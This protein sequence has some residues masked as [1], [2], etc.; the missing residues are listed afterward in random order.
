MSSVSNQ[1]R[2]SALNST[3]NILVDD[4]VVKSQ[5]WD[6][7]G[8]ERFASLACSSKFKPKMQ[9][10]LLREHLFHV[11]RKALEASDKPTALP[12]G[13]TINVGSKDDV[14]AVKTGGFCST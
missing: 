7:I 13:Q 9:R 6:T 5:I 1:S 8:Q 10:H 3:R 4:M 12:K 14:S 11:S 2:R